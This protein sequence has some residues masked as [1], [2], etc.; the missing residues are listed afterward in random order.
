MVLFGI[1]TTNPSPRLCLGIGFATLLRRFRVGSLAGRSKFPLRVLFGIRTTNPSPRLC[2]GIG[3]AT[4]LRRFRVG[5]L[6]GRSKFPLRVLFGIRTTNPSPRLA[7]ELGS[8]HCSAASASEALQGGANS[9][10]GY[11]WAWFF[12]AHLPFLILRTN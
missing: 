5:S 6:A 11:F 2:L 7:S 3:F 12:L 9:R 1:R 8:Q 4:L 10:C